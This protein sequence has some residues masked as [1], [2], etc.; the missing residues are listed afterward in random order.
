MSWINTDHPA[1]LPYEKRPPVFRVAVFV[2]VLAL[3]GL[4]SLNGGCAYM[5][6]RPAVE[7][8]TE[9]L[10]EVYAT[11]AATSRSTEVALEAGRVTPDQAEDILEELNRAD[12]LADQAAVV[13]GDGGDAEDRMARVESILLSIEQELQEEVDDE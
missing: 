5:P 10:G 13:I 9:R 7:T 3:I 12:E 4:G 8:P 6:E 1:E 2:M 11:I